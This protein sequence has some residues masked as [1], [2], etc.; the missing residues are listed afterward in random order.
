M[1]DRTGLGVIL[2]I[3]GI[4]LMD[5][6]GNLFTDSVGVYTYIFLPL[7]ILGILAVFLDRKRYDPY[8]SKLA[9]LS[10]I[11]IIVFFLLY[12]TLG[13]LNKIYFIHNGN[14]R[15]GL[16][17]IYW[18]EGLQVLGFFSYIISVAGLNRESLNRIAARGM[19]IAL[20]LVITTIVLIQAPAEEMMEGL[21]DIA[22]DE[23]T[24]DSRRRA[25]LGN[26]IEE[27]NKGLLLPKLPT[28]FAGIVTLITVI[29]LS[30]DQ[31]KGIRKS[32]MER[33]RGNLRS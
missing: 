8:H 13:L 24:H 18:S 23:N 28:V 1:R 11:M 9:G 26:E 12:L 6:L 16:N 3:T 31:L 2:I 10:L 15:I 19:I 17:I 30:R 32:F 21:D 22:N 33:I 29:I 27:Y 14:F 25:M 4:F 5:V 20:V 7:P